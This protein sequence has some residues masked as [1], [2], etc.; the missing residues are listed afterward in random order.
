MEIVF[1][2]AAFL[3][4]C[5]EEGYDDY[6]MFEGDVYTSAYQLDNMLCH[7]EFAVDGRPVSVGAVS[8]G[9]NGYLVAGQVLVTWM[10]GSDLEA[11]GDAATPQMMADHI[12]QKILPRLRADLPQRLADPLTCPE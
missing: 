8:T 5:E 4:F 1:D 7:A 9:D 11:L 10:T 12:E 2:R 6:G 3:T